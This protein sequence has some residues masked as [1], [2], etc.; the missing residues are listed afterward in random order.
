MFRQCEDD[1]DFIMLGGV[2]C[3][4]VMGYAGSCE[5]DQGAVD[6]NTGVAASEACPI[7]CGTGCALTF[8]SC[9]DQQ[10]TCQNGGVCVNRPG[11][12]AFGCDCPHGYCG[13]ACEAALDPSLSQCPVS[14]IKETVALKSF[15]LSVGHL[16]PYVLPMPLPHNIS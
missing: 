12:G 4:T 10:E 8:D 6:D 3:S 5:A 1:P 2:T 16:L 15:G 14:P 13:F 7:S 11:V 9:W